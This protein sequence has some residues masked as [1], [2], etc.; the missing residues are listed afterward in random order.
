MKN[1]NFIANKYIV[2]LL[3]NF[4]IVFSSIRF[5]L[6]F[7]NIYIFIVY[8]I[9]LNIFVF[10]IYER[11]KRSIVKLFNWKVFIVFIA[12]CSFFLY[13]IIDARKSEK[14]KGSTGDEAL[15]LSANTLKSSCKL[16]DA[17]IDSTT[18][19]SPGPGWV[20]LNSPFVLLNVYFLFTPFYIFV[21]CLVLNK[22]FN[23]RMSN[24]FLL[25]LSM[26]MLF[27]ELIL[28]GH[29]IFPLSAM[30]FLCSI[31][32]FQYLTKKVRI[33]VLLLISVLIGIVSTSRVVFVFYPL[34]LSV[35]LWKLNRKNALVMFLT[36]MSVFLFLN[37]FFYSINT[38]YQPIHLF[39]KAVRNINYGMIVAGSVGFAAGLFFQY[40]NLKNN[41]VS[42]NKNLF[43]SFLVVFL[44]IASGDLIKSKFN[45]L[46]WEGANYLMPVIPF[47][48]L[49]VYFK[50]NDSSECVMYLKEGAITS[51]KDTNGNDLV[52]ISGRIQ[53]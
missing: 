48:L 11:Y 35:F 34:L 12:I 49:Y 36:S 31:L 51:G 3:F 19:I 40:R 21:L 43:I 47:L 17:T 39:D 8:G 13:P 46:T 20:I 42:W 53:N 6:K 5:F 15:I 10:L 26:S 14:G 24:F 1:I 33:D 18:P 38:Y 22:V 16:Y 45:F 52:F 50:I 29:D 44:P 41:I 30:L 32:V 7:T 37:L 28:N 25:F 4:L 23:N 9:L 27:W 2:V